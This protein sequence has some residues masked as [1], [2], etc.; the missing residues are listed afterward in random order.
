MSF[1]SNSNDNVYPPTFHSY[2]AQ[3]FRKIPRLIKIQ[4]PMKGM[5]RVKI[6]M[7]I[8]KNFKSG[9]FQILTKLLNH[10]LKVKYFLSPC[11][12]SAVCP[13]FKNVGECSSVTI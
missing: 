11:K 7:V 3:T 12:T 9:L 13:V 5:A 10:Y 1:V 6:P 8:I 2:G 4:P